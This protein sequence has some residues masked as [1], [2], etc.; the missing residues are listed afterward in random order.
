MPTL[1]DRSRFLELHH[2]TLAIHTDGVF[3][4]GAW[5]LQH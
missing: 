3:R 4:G 5:L 2:A 1:I